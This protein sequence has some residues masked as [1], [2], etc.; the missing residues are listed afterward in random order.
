MFAFIAILGIKL[1]DIQHTAGIYEQ[2][3]IVI[4]GVDSLRPDVILEPSNPAPYIKDL[5]S[6]NVTYDN[7]YT[8]LAR[9][10][11]SWMTVL[12]GK[13]PHSS[14][15][16]VNLQTIDTSEIPIGLGHYLQ[17]Q[18]YYTVYGSDEKRFSNIDKHFGFNKVIGP[19]I[20][21]H[22]FLFGHIDAIV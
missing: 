4:I 13:H 19:S 11:P 16:R 3:N 17:D 12:T 6:A 5:T 18:G 22:D 1:I 7:A 8:P 2:P 9:T 20:G 14:G 10:F 21:I 15:M